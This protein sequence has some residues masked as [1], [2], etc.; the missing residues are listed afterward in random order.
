MANGKQHVAAQRIAS[1]H[2]INIYMP[3]ANSVLLFLCLFLFLSYP[4]SLL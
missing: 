2:P 3:N 1:V 4:L